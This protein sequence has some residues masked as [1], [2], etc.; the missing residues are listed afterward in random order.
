LRRTTASRQYGSLLVL[1]HS[2]ES[3]TNEEWD[4]HMRLLEQ[5]MREHRSV[6][7]IVLTEGGAPSATQRAALTKVLGN[8][9]TRSAILTRSAAVRTVLTALR[10]WNPTIV[11]FTPEELPKAMEFLGVEPKMRGTIERT[12]SELRVEVEQS[13]PKAAAR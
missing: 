2:S 5:M 3:P 9:P 1:F 10:F 11:G 12:F 8:G 7:T 6:N 13:L 4:A